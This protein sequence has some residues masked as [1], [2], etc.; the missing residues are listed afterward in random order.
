MDNNTRVRDI[1]SRS[2]GKSVA[3]LGAG[4]TGRA[5][6]RLL[7]QAGYQVYVI[8]EK[9]VHSGKREQIE[10]FGCNLKEQFKG[11]TSDLAWL[12][13][14]DPSFAVVSPGIS[15][16]GQL[17]T[18]IRSARI[19]ILTEIDIAVA[20][21]GSPLV[22]VTG[23]NGKTTCA[24][25]IFQM[26]KKSELPV[27]L[28]GN[29]GNPFVDLIQADELKGKGTR[30]LDPLMVAEVS[31]YQ[32]EGAFDFSPQISVCLNVQDDHL[33]R[34]GTI[35]EYAKIKA[36]IF[37][38]QKSDSQSWSLIWKDDPFY[39]I[40]RQYLNA[41][42]MF[43]GIGS[44]SQ[45]PASLVSDDYQSLTIKTNTLEQSFSLRDFKLIGKHNYL[46]IAASS[47]AALLAGA[48]PEA[49]QAVINEFETLPHRIEPILENAGI[50]YINDSKGTNTASVIAALEGLGAKYPRRPVVLLL[51]GKN[52]QQSWKELTDFFGGRVRQAILFGGDR[53]LIAKII[54]N[55]TPDFF[56]RAVR[57]EVDLEQAL[58]AAQSI[59][60]PGDIV[61]LSPGCA[62][63][64]AY[65]GFE[66]RGEH[67]RRLLI[68]WAKQ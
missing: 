5:V 7:A 12:R 46:N 30:S 8:D 9:L 51:G 66:E 59:A 52:K 32:L 56:K 44:V 43:F 61:L 24:N 35:N 16:E 65:S 41:Q 3:V 18:L 63:F 40:Y 28:V 31:S 17:V 54:E 53:E 50:L 67:F 38:N 26:L 42:E 19:P 68:D 64:D 11:G 45:G 10:Q 49:I 14:V 34:H 58:H 22:A 6:M 2:A 39:K 55:C 60:E 33:E 37:A 27:H 15:L 29:V 62:S 20:F 21:L 4:V 25:L 48:R 1:L 13:G 47:A 36:R 57:V 23:T